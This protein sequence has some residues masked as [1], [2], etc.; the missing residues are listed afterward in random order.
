MEL[1][2]TTF[3]RNPQVSWRPMGDDCVLL[4][5]ETGYYYTLNP[6]GRFIWD[7]LASP[8]QMAEVIARVTDEYDVDGKTAGADVEEILTDLAQEN[9][10]VAHE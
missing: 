8:L 5:L 3:I 4:H 9:L 2:T 6:V 10:I 1:A 7:L